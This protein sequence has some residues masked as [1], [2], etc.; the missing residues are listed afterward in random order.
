MVEYGFLGDAGSGGGSGGCIVGGSAPVRV[1]LPVAGLAA[2]VFAAEGGSAAAGDGDGVA[3]D[4]LRRRPEV[5]PPPVS[6][7]TCGD[8]KAS[9]RSAWQV[10]PATAAP[11]PVKRL[12][13]QRQVA[14][15]HRRR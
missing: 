11:V 15:G 2:G 13:S 14:A 6:R 3:G 5:M 8:G 1:R 12:G 4:I 9:V 7:A 10:R